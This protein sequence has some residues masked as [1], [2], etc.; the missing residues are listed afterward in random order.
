MVSKTDGDGEEY[1]TSSD[2]I[3]F[4]EKSALV[5]GVISPGADRRVLPCY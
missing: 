2:I 4:S 3:L 1:E 5:S